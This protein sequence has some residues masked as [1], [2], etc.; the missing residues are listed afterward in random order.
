MARQHRSSDSGS[1]KHLPGDAEPPGLLRIVG[2]ELRGRKLQYSGDERTRPMKDRVREAIFNLIGP[3]VI[4]GVAIDVFAGTGALGLEALSRG[5][6]RTLLVE[7]HFPTANL[8]RK[9]LADLGVSDRGEVYPANAFIWVQRLPAMPP[10]PWIVFCSPPYAFFVD[11]RD[12]MLK[13]IGTL[14]DQAPAESMFIVEA[15]ERFDFGLLPAAEEWDLRNYPPAH[16]GL[17]IKPA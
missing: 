2:G 12:E 16:V 1:R 3:R 13:L 8:I 10:G 14:I 6:S 11:R 7:Q 15:D 5:A 4:G 17:W 9:N